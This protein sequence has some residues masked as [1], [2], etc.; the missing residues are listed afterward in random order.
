MNNN[1]VVQAESNTAIKDVKKEVSKTSKPRLTRK[2]KLLQKRESLLTKRQQE[3][4][5]LDK[6][7]KQLEREEKKRV[8]KQLTGG[9]SA[10]GK[11]MLT[12][13]D[14]SQLENWKTRVK[15]GNDDKKITDADFQKI[16]ATIDYLL[17]QI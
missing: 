7:L 5:D 14:K 3:L 16:N 17:S 1:S 11:A 12:L 2:E 13:A 10:F 4:K 9:Y 6:E 8:S 15:K